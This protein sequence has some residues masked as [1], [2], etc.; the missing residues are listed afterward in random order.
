MAQ[1]L[2]FP[3]TPT[4][5]TGYLKKISES[6]ENRDY[7]EFVAYANLMMTRNPRIRSHFNVRT[8]A[9]SSFGWTIE[10]PD[11]PDR[12]VEVR[13]RS[14]SAIQT[15]LKHHA[16]TPFWGVL[17]FEALATTTPNGNVVGLK[18]IANGRIIPKGDI[19]QL[20]D[21]NKPPRLADI[22]PN[23]N[24]YLVDVG[25][26]SILADIALTE[27][28][29]QQAI[30]ENYQY[31][32]VLKG[33]VQLIN[34]DRS[35]ADEDIAKTNEAITNAQKSQFVSSTEDFEIKVNELTKANSQAFAEFIERSNADIAI[36]C[37]GQANTTQLGA[38][39]SRAALQVLKMISAD[40]HFTDMLR[41]Q[42]LINRYLLIDYRLNFDA[43]AVVA[44]Y[45]FE[46]N[47]EEE[48]NF[49][50]NALYISEALNTGLDFRRS[51]I[52]AKLG[53]SQPEEG[54]DVVRLVNGVIESGGAVANV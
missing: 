28:Y 38:S 41:V 44:P 40:I 35:M 2:K 51:E 24:D 10:F 53:L 43:T 21:E 1:L 25:T 27:F 3:D 50:D 18:K 8:T 33:I 48:Q 36:A 37:L 31:I 54:D 19:A 26:S 16:T 46:W 11:Q 17:G 15:I 52:Y 9:V 22:D 42:D 4:V 14:N 30:S 47:W 45:F 6:E 32:K 39:G 23:S 5:V 49:R 7:S 12:A 13:N 20:A 34:K 29:R